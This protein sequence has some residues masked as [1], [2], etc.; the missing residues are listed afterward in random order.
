MEL[1]APAPPGRGAVPRQQIFISGK[2]KRRPSGRRFFWCRAM[3]RLRNSKRVAGRYQTCRVTIIFLIS[4]MA[5]AGFRP[6]G[7]IWAQFMMV[8]QR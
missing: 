6:F 1:M 5:F 4:A 3:A 7:Q 8:W 2:Q